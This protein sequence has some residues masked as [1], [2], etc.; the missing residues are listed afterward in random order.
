MSERKGDHKVIKDK[1]EHKSQKVA[2]N[3]QVIKD[4]S[5][6]KGQK[7]AKNHQWKNSSNGRCRSEKGLKQVPLPDPPKKKKKND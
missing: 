3:H 6:H 1:S 5:E 4:K 7:V 2:K